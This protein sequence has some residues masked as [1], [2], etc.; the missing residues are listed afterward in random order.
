[1][2][3]SDRGA[4]APAR[5]QGTSR[6]DRK[7]AA[8]SDRG[9]L[10]EYI[11]AVQDVTRAASAEP[12]LLDPTVVANEAVIALVR[13]T[14]MPACS[15]YLVDRDAGIARCIAH[16]GYPEGFIERYGTLPLGGDTLT[17]RALRTGE[18]Q[19]SGLVSPL[20]STADVMNL[21][22]SNT[23][24]IVPFRSGS[25]VT[26]TINIVGTRRE[27]PTADE[28][29]L[30]Q[31]FAGQVGHAVLATQLQRDTAQSN[32]R[33]SFLAAVS[34]A[35]NATLDLP[36]VLA[37]VAEHATRVLGDWCMIYLRE[38]DLMQMRAVHHPDPHRAA[39][40]REVFAARPVRV[41]EGVAGTVVVTG[42]ARIFPQ[43]GEDEIRVL[44]PRNDPAY[45]NEL[46]KVQSW[47]CLP[48][49]SHGEGVGAL[50]IATVERALTQ[51]DLDFAGAFA[52][53]A[54]GAIANAR[55]FEAE[56]NLREFAEIARERLAEADHLKDDFLSIASHELRTPL[57]SAQ[58]FTQVLLR[59]A[60]R[61]E[62]RDEDLIKIL[63]SVETQLRRMTMLLND[64][65]D[66]T[67][68]QSGGL[69]LHLSTVDLRQLAIDVVQRLRRALDEDRIGIEVPDEPVT[70][71][72]DSDRIEQVIVNLLNNAVKYSPDGGAIEVTVG[73]ENGWALLAVR[74]HGL[75]VP[76]ASVSRLFERFYR[77]P[78]RA[79]Q[80]ISGIGIG[81]YICR[82]I[83]KRHAGTIA[84][85]QPGG[86]G[87]K[88]V[89]RLPL[90]TKSAPAP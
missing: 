36:E 4:R 47:A 27:A 34:R 22:G 45:L 37:V 39:I 73:R 46:R 89:V 76:P 78:N 29:A 35:F 48:L 52:E 24:I 74:D 11:G 59:R 10:S 43:F 66:F 82:E 54:A 87:A 53:I 65:M 3:E 1:M 49:F 38:G 16:R 28:I 69:P 32:Q 17:T 72:W 44:A 88:F 64:L 84:V 33:A 2:A 25:E 15:V 67:H 31:V 42:Q 80:Q 50:L 23:F 57:T 26:G 77:I 8:D 68:V 40:V 60:V 83:A 86:A 5:L 55:L 61:L 51:E 7:A 63:S 18:P 85:E 14:G 41:G 9:A 20:P 79:H 71:S 12:S 58:G 81:L 56:R 30:L 90:E 75:G 62:N 6:S 13:I 19:Y 70:G 21:V